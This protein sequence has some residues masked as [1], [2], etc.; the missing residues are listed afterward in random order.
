MTP[1]I[2][3]FRVFLPAQTHA[4]VK[5]TLDSAQLG[6]GRQV[7]EF[8]SRLGRWL[9]TSKLCSLSDFSGAITL[10]LYAA[11]VRPGDEVILSPLT[12]LATSMPV[13]NL[14]AKPVWC[15]VDPATGIMDASRVEALITEKTRAI[16]VYH[17][18]G[19]VADLGALRDIARRAGI[20]LIEDASEAFGAEQGGVKLGS[21]T[22]NFTVFSF[23]PVRHLTCAEG[24]AI[25]TDNQDSIESLGKL[26]RY[27][28]DKATFRLD[29]GDLNPASDIPVAGFNFPMNNLSAAIGIAQ[30][31]GLD[32]NLQKHR[33]NGACY[34]DKLADV[35]GITLL[36]RRSDSMSSYWTY[37]MRAERRDD[38]IQKLI[39]HGIGSQRLHLRNDDYSCFSASK[40][41]EPMPGVD[42]FD[43]ENISIP[44]GWWVGEA[45]REIIISCIRGGW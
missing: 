29:N 23:G 28:I 33:E 43:K 15:D 24:A 32:A 35:P 16:L 5:S 25:T 12:C 27:G 11:G 14:F 4:T 19:D 17:W 8:E 45:E 37:S 13:C 9:G 18:S 6:Q 42:T 39:A 41:T 34:Q 21:G 38:L 1:S 10:A 20:A 3:L 26:R 36:S 40:K 2:P 44:C 31:Q 30:F 22:A 7:A